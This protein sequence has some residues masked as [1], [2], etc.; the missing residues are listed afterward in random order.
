MKSHI[1]LQLGCLLLVWRVFRMP[2]SNTKREVFG[3]DHDEDN[4]DLYDTKV[5]VSFVK[6]DD[7][8]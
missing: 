6:P 7:Y 1:Y 3:W 4:V 8:C 2:I 5:Q